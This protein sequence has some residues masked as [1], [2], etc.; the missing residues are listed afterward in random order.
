M[1]DIRKNSNT[2]C[3]ILA[4]TYISAIRTI[5]FGGVVSIAQLVEV[6]ESAVL[7]GVVEVVSSI[8]AVG[9]KIFFSI[10]RHS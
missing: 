3:T 10:F 6:T 8:P 4:D 7:G 9:H 1:L 2:T 5:F